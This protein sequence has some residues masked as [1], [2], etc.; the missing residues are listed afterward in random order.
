MQHYIPIM[1]MTV[2]CKYIQVYRDKYIY[3]ETD[4]HRKGEN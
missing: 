4:K 1:Y 3:E 2:V